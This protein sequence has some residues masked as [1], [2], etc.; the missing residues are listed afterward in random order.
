MFLVLRPKVL[1][2]G[3]QRAERCCSDMRWAEQGLLGFLRPREG[4]ASCGS[5]AFALHHSPGF[6]FLLKLQCVAPW[7][8]SEAFWI[9]VTNGVRAVLGTKASSSHFSEWKAG[10]A[11]ACM[12]CCY[13]NPMAS[14]SKGALSA[15]LHE[16]VLHS[17]K[18]P[19]WVCLVVQSC[20]TLCDLMDCS[21]ASSSV[22]GILQARI[23]E[24]VAIPFS[25]GSSQPRDWTQVP[26]IVVRFFTVWATQ[27]ASECS[28]GHKLQQFVHNTHQYML[29]SACPGR[30]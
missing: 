3:G 16:G 30:R 28:Y 12:S 20:P 19:E 29:S 5:P 21:P 6:L 26:Y 9:A 10:K 18:A 2:W 22:H 25:R 7:L 8:D 15:T 1:P 13:A 23:L 11:G 24:W 14:W 17:E 4:S 27:K